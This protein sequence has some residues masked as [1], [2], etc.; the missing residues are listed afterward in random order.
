MSIVSASDYS[1]HTAATRLLFMFNALAGASALS[2]TLSYLI[3]VYS[4]LRE[5]NTV[6]LTV[7]MM[8]DCTGDAARALTRLG[9]DGKF[10]GGYSELANLAS[11]VAALKEAHHFYPL[12]F[13]FRFRE[14]RYSVSRICFVILDLTTLIRTGLDQEQFGWLSRSSA[15]TRL[16]QGGELLLHVLRLGLPTRQW[17]QPNHDEQISRMTDHYAACC[18][19]L[20]ASGLK[21]TTDRLEKYVAERLQWERQIFCV[22][23]VLGY[24]LEDVTGTDG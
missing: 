2:L 16:G 5:R 15:V 7:D 11:S 3:Q 18:H 23:P 22:A 1:P 17:S 24:T 4:A 19:E 6:A 14:P 8:T 12:L 21:T 13:Y 9:S 20:R 10:Q